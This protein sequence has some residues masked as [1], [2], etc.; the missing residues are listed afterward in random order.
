M[1]SAMTQ[2]Q[3]TYHQLLDELALLP[4]FGH[5]PAIRKARQRYKGNLPTMYPVATPGHQTNTSQATNQFPDV[6]LKWIPETTLPLPPL[7]FQQPAAV[8]RP[9]CTR[10]RTL[11]YACCPWSRSCLRVHSRPCRFCTTIPNAPPSA[12]PSS[13]CMLGLPPA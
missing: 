9:I 6:S 1:S 10:L 4:S 12:H 5:T 11:A 7:P 3:S 8:A 2:S 13:P